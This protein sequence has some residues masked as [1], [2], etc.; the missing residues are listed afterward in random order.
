MRRLRLR[1]LPNRWRITLWIAASTLLVTF[2]LGLLAVIG[3]R[4][5]FTTRIDSELRSQSAQVASVIEVFDLDQL[6]RIAEP[7]AGS[8]LS[9]N[10]YGILVSEADGGTLDVQPGP[11]DDPDPPLD[12]SPRALGELRARAGSPFDVDSADGSTAYRA[13]VT[14]LDDGGLLVMY[15]PLSDRDDAVRTVLNVFAVAGIGETI[16]I[17]LVVAVV[18]SLV[19]RPLDSMIDTAAAIGDGDLT[20][21][22]ETTGGVEDVNRLATALNHM[23]DRLQEAFDDRQASEDALRRFVAD[24]S[25]ELRTPLAAVLGYAELHET[26][27]AGV[28]DVPRSMARIRA[29]G[30]RMRLLVEE[31]LTLARLDEGRPMEREP[32]DLSDLA[33]LAADDATAAGPDHPVA[34]EVPPNPV[35]L[36]GD[37]MSL[38]QA[39]DNLLVNARTHT[40]A[41]TA[42]T[43]RVRRADGDAV[44]EVV[45]AGPGLDAVA[46]DHIFERFY[47]AAA[48]RSRDA[49]GG[50]GLGLA[51]VAAIAEAHGGRATVVTAEGAGA[52]FALHLPLTTP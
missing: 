47:R 3:V 30:E 31:L 39:V 28:D 35:V 51:I 10:S 14:Q 22:V 6:K 49:G 52:T 25:H 9:P 38:R 1:R 41:G 50:S 48:S 23:L 16:L 45:D 4:Q 8:G 29:E 18:T 42:V 15:R 37:A 20:S 33:R 11:R 43:V 7:S 32:V 2:L 34:V 24:A 40:P 5:R 46:A 17:C 36:A 12:T 44:I 13:L 21:R 19:T 26:G 27:M